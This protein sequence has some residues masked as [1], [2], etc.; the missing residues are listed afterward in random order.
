MYDGAYD[1]MWKVPAAIAGDKERSKDLLMRYIAKGRFLMTYHCGGLNS[2]MSV[3][4]A[5]TRCDFGHS[6]IYSIE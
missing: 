2:A 4:E 6:A 1:S 5:L 3:A